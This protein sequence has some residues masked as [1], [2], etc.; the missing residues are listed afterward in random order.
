MVRGMQRACHCKWERVSCEREATR[1]ERGRYGC[2]TCGRVRG[3][4][5]Q[6]GRQV[7]VQKA[8]S[9]EVAYSRIRC[10]IPIRRAF[11]PAPVHVSRILPSFPAPLA[12]PLIIHGG[13]SLFVFVSPRLCSPLSPLPAGLACASATSV[14]SGGKL[15]KDALLPCPPYLQSC[16]QTRHS[17]L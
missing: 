5:V 14:H 17:D 9:F 1:L 13:L 3:C 6:S 7:H 11:A 12:L 16:T 10:R 4:G 8:T 2:G 15:H